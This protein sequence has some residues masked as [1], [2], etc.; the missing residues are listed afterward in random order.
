ML[1]KDKNLS[2]REVYWAQELSS[3]MLRKKSLPRQITQILHH[4]QSSP[5]KVFSFVINNL[6]HCP[7][8]LLCRSAVM[9]W[10]CQFRKFFTD[11]QSLKKP[12]SISIGAIW[13]KLPML[14]DNNIDTKEIWLKDVLMT[15]K[16]WKVYFS[17]MTSLN[18]SQYFSHDK[19]R[20]VDNIFSDLNSTYI[21]ELLTCI[22]YLQINVF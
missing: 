8:V 19:W 22:G 16:I 14:R 10:L 20:V 3:K 11:K 13:L 7:Q 1:H 21:L 9:L 2:S 6:S 17:I 18:N 15:A 12:Y 4:L 5:T